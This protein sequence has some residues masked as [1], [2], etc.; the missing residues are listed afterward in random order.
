MI[1]LHP[2][3]ACPQSDPAGE[4]T[5]IQWVSS[6][7]LDN[8]TLA[9]EGMP[10]SMMVVKEITRCDE[11]GHSYTTSYRYGGGLYGYYNSQGTSVVRD[12][13]FRG[14]AWSDRTLPSGLHVLTRNHRQEN[15][16]GTPGT[17]EKLAADGTVRTRESSL[18]EVRS[19][20]V[21]NQIL[22]VQSDEEMIDPGGALH[23]R[24]NACYKCGRSLASK[25]HELSGWRKLLRSMAFRPLTPANAGHRSSHG[26]YC[27]LMVSGSNSL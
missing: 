2:P 23:S 7:G 21:G 10:V 1:M 12:R 26:S 15:L 11:R 17:V 18:Y 13:R 3:R 19:I 5:D 16:S 14:F 25:A 22:L 9:G 20:S 4:V 6:T 8:G 24:L 27:R